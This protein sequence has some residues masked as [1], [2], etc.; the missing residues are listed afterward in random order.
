V[1]HPPPLQPLPPPDRIAL[2][3]IVRGVALLGI[4]LMNIEAFTGPLDLSFTGI[5]PHWQGLDYAADALVYV[6]VQGKFFLLF[7]LMFGAGF[8]VMEQRAR[9]AGRRFVP[10]YLRRSAVLLLIGAGHALLLWSGDILMVYALLSFPLLLCRRLPLPLLPVAGVLCYLLAVGLT[11]LFSAAVLLA[12]SSGT[13]LDNGPSM[14]MAEQI[15]QA[16][17]QAY[18]SG[19]WLQATAQRAD[20]VRRMIGGLLITGPEVFGMFLLGMWFTR[21]GALAQP[22]RFAGLYRRLRCWAGPLGLVLVLLGAVW[23]PYMA[24]G[25]FTAVTGVAY[26]VGAVG[27]LLMCLG[28]LAWIVRWRHRLGAFA[29]PGRMALSNYLLQSLLCTGLFYG[30]GLGAFEVLPRSAQLPV[31][32]GLFALQLL[33][34]HGWLARFRFGPV[35]WLWRCAT[36]LRVAPLRSATPRR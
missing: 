8:A 26:A 20:D 12:A 15:I 23:H 18:G 3:D 29:A 19:S 16:Q 22:E 4:L 5:D 28:Y 31:A 25:E 13:V 24:P 21:S 7:S 9:Q 10:M 1:T 32:L 11:V 17:R 35:E 6:L 2:M 27:S 14:A 33:A 36:Y 34:S 30:Y